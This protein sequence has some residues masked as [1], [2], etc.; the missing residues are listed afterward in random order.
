MAKLYDTEKI[1]NI[2]FFGHRGSGKTSLAE[3]L[4]YDTGV[5]TRLGSVEAK[6]SLFDYL[7]EEKSKGFSITSMPGWVEWK[8]T[9]I[10]FLDTP[11]DLNFLGDSRNMLGVIDLAVF[12][13]SANDGVEVGTEILWEAADRKSIPR[14]ILVNKCDCERSHASDMLAELKGTFRDAPVVALQLPIG[15]A[16]QFEGVVDLMSMRSFKF[17]SDGSGAFEEGDVPSDMESEVAEAREALMYKIAESDEDLEMKL[18]EEGELNQE[19]MNAG[20]GAAIKG[21]KLYPILFGSA[22]ANIGMKALLDLCVD[23]GPNPLE[24]APVR[25]FNE[26][27]EEVLV[28]CSKDGE[29]A[30]IFFKTILSRVGKFGIFRVFRGFVDSSIDVSNTTQDSHGRLGS[31]LQFQGKD[32][33][34]MERAVTGDLVGVA[35]LKSSHAGDSIS[36][37][38]DKLR[39]DLIQRPAPLIAYALKCD[40]EDKTVQALQ[41]L[42]EEDLSL[43][44]GRDS[45]SHELLLK[46]QGQG[47]IDVIVDRLEHEF[48]Q[49]VELSLPTVA[50]KE[51]IRSSVKNVE[52]KLKKQSGGRGQYGVC[53]I[54]MKPAEEGAGFV[55]EDAIVGGT[56][57]K[58]YIPA[59]EKGIQEASTRGVLAGFPTIDFHVRLFDGKTHNVDSSEQAFKMAGSF[60]FKNA[61]A[62]CKPVLLEPYVRLEVTVPSEFQGEISGDLNRRRGRIEETTYRG[63]NVTISA[64]VPKGEV[65]TYANQLISMTEGRGV[66]SVEFSHYDQVPPLQQK[67]ILEQVNAGKEE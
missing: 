53:F 67:Q 1:R 10:N 46:G 23:F 20:L 47:H 5:T 59:V 16:T 2:G 43:V 60:A 14:V 8:G 12:V 28:E 6:T 29:F 41:R 3:A 19:D 65:L 4:L 56:I 61:V 45:N 63:K 64:K 32:S 26:K 49:K 44:L 55:F 33:I 15:K 35:K 36:S 22:T 17:S 9:K 62:K 39:F 66:F 27:D 34:P 57:P 54:D 24:R 37:S 11:G 13:I 31:L 42:A 40:D 38:K 18:L 25:A 52:G 48:G 21:G 50:Y 7:E 51:T 30:G 58:Q